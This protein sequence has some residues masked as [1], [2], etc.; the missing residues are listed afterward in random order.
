MD[1]LIAEIKLKQMN[2]LQIS[3]DELVLIDLC[4]N[5]NNTINKFLK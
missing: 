3:I 5:K 2:K 1:L 4:D